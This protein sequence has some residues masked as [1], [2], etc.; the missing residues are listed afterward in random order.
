[1]TTQVQQKRRP[2]GGSTIWKWLFGCIWGFWNVTI[3][4]YYVFRRHRFS[5]NIKNRMGKKV[6][7]G[8]L[9]GKFQAMFVW[10]Q[11]EKDER[12]RVY[13]APQSVSSVPLAVILHTSQV[14]SIMPMTVRYFQLRDKCAGDSLTC[15]VCQYG[16]TVDVLKLFS[17]LCDVGDTVEGLR[18]Q[19][20]SAIFCLY[21]T[22]SLCIRGDVK[23]VCTAV[24]SWHR[25]GKPLGEHDRNELWLI[26]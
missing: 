20:T 25:Y 23:A 8:E 26:D 24:T 14:A 19:A 4:N 9:H 13:K 18:C 12:H 15:I 1:M 3:Q 10:I 16:Q 2:L 6:Q 5:L 17:S 11:Q 22:H 7:R 21:L